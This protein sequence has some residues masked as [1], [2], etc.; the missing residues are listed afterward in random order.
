[1]EE[2]RSAEPG[3]DASHP[4]PPQKSRKK[5]LLAALAA[6]LLC[7][8]CLALI[9]AGFA[10]YRA[11][12]SDLFGKDTQPKIVEVTVAVTPQETPA[13]QSTPPAPQPAAAGSGLGVS[14]AEM[15]DFFGSGGAFEFDAPFTAQGK[16]V[17]MGSHTWLC[18]EGDCAAV[19][20]LGPEENLEAV[21]VAV[22]TDPNDDT[23]SATAMT[24]L[25]TLASRFSSSS[26]TTPFDVLDAVT[27]AQASR[28]N[29][30]ATFK[31]NGYT[32]NVSYDAASGIAALAVSR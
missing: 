18:L 11:F 4:A 6:V 21:S 12:G 28:Q 24:L 10:A 14:R 2:P 26:S 30:E 20:L 29:K 16:E 9:T 5:Y 15:I 31:N 27:K 3:S 8:L 1:M 22:P 13:L 19:T 32:F 25:M 17:V 23:Q 7:C